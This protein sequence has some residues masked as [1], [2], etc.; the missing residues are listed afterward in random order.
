MAG[1][2]C[3]TSTNVTRKAAAGVASEGPLV[4]DSGEVVLASVAPLKTS[5]L[6]NGVHA[7][8]LKPN[9]TVSS[10]QG[11]QA[12]E[13]ALE[14]AVPTVQTHCF[15][16]V[17]PVLAV[18]MFDPHTVHEALDASFFHEP[19]GHN[20]GRGGEEMSRRAVDGVLKGHSAPEA[21]TT[22]VPLFTTTV[23]GGAVTQGPGPAR[24]L[25]KPGGQR[26]HVR[27]LD[28]LPLAAI[29]KRSNGLN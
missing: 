20:R 16:S 15:A 18:V 21:A 13:L 7:L 2:S 11:T 9:A 3:G 19:G 8:L 23:K 29:P 27:L 10:G 6:D 22:A 28:W 4:R 25:K 12:E 24:I 5:Q 17:E 14:R 26:T 1:C